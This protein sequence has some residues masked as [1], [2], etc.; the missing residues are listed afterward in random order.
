MDTA[1]SGRSAPIRSWRERTLQTGAFELGG[2]LLVSPLW[3]MVSG[4]SAGESVFLLLC[5][6]AAVMTWMAAYNTAFDLTEARLAGRVASERP[7]RWRMAHAVGLEV[8]SMLATWPLI[9]LVTGLGWWEA[10]AADLG[11]TAAYAVYGYFF[12]L[13]FDRLR[14]VLRSPVGGPVAGQV[15]GRHCNG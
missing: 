14:P 9:A 7:H 13:A 6:S 2:L 3:T 1:V 10:L 8:S 11:L 15:G 4:D 5:L 12:H